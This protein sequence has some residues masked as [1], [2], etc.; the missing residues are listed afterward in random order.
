VV[1]LIRLPHVGL[2][3]IFTVPNFKNID[4]FRYGRTVQEGYKMIF[5][6]VAATRLEGSEVSCLAQPTLHRELRK[7]QVRSHMGDFMPGDVE[8]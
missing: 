7:R 2:L 5:P 1:T 4:I 3:V 8:H 6:E